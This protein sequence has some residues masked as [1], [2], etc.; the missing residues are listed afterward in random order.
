MVVF[1]RF[2]HQLVS[3][4]FSVCAVCTF[5]QRKKAMSIS[6]NFVWLFNVNQTHDGGLNVCV[7]TFALSKNFCLALQR[8]PDS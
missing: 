8:Q 1:T 7:Q 5:P 6:N 4:R 3:G 2:A